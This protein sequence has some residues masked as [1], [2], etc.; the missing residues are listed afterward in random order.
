MYGF[1][2]MHPK[3]LLTRTL[4]SADRR[5]VDPPPIVEL[6][7]F[8]GEGNAM[9]EITFSYSANFFLFAT[10]ENARSIAQGRVPQNQANCPVLT[11]MP[12]AGIAYLDRPTPAGY[13]IFPDLSV[14]HEGKYRLSFQLYEELKEEKDEDIVDASS[15]DMGGGLGAHVSPRLEVKSAPFLVYSAKKFPGLAE[16]TALSRMVAD[17]GCRVRIRR[18]VRMRRRDNKHTKDWD[19][20]D[21]EAAYEHTRRTATPDAYGQAS[22][23][24]PAPPIERPR[25]AS[26][27]SNASFHPSVQHRTSMPELAQSYQQQSYAPQIAPQTPQ[28]TYPSHLTY[29]PTSTS[30]YPAAHYMQQQTMVP[31]PQP[32][33]QYQ[34]PSAYQPQ[35]SMS[36]A[37]T[38]Q[39]MPSQ[40]YQPPQYEQPSHMRQES[41][42]YPPQADYRRATMA[43]P[44]QYHNQNQMVQS[45]GSMDYSRPPV[46]HQ[47]S[48]Q[49]SDPPPLPL[50]PA[51]AAPAQPLPPL[52]SL[53]VA[54]EKVEP[55]SPNAVMPVHPPPIA[56]PSYYDTAQLEAPRP[57]P[58]IP[59]GKRSYGSVFNTTHMDQ[60]LRGGARPNLS[61]A[62][63]AYAT[64]TMDDEEDDDC[65]DMDALKMHYRRADGTEISRRIPRSN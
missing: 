64:V 56:G 45:Y 28:T 43:Y 57:V 35:T 17:Q 18:D 59:G 12:V 55:T 6:R 3:P 33:V 63:T 19:E 16:S 36:V 22:A 58:Q 46:V 65:F 34:H 50:I 24:T 25:S 2:G 11:G 40:Q 41:L 23:S 20:Y 49:Y 1:R 26:N 13:F 7:V 52:K 38:Y 15:P 4:A 14:R 10:L 37:Q 61:Q 62:E 27:A 5:P 39:Y 48:N 30:T 60:P 21:D 29:A 42:E 53:P 9:N 32:V 51:A 8:E 44:Q 47:P 31:P 54:V